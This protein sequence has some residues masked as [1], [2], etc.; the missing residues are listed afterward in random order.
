MDQAE[1]IRDSLAKVEAFRHAGRASPLLEA[2][3]V[4]VKNLQSLQ[5][6]GTYADLAKDEQFAPATNFFLDKL[7]GVHDFA[8]RDA[9]F[10]KMA[11]ALERVLPGPAISTAV[12]LASLHA[13]SEEL[14]YGMAATLV[15]FSV[16]PNNE[17]QAAANYVHAWR[18]V[19][20][21]VDRWRQ[22]QMVLTLGRD[23]VRLTNTRGLRIILRMMHSPAEAAGFGALQH[24]LECGFDTF[25]SM[26]KQGGRAAQFLSTIENRESDLI[27]ML[28]DEELSIC[29]SKLARVFEPSAR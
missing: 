20:R 9:Q 26:S 17:N 24:F 6:R 25:A 14:D 3:V 29:K 5:F 11:G 27:N 10:C 19:G 7:Y 1:K 4:R 13:L 28:F 18:Q 12:T 2:S 22:L 16:S 15:D 8:S 21:H 23:L